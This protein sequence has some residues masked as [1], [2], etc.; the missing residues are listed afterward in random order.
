MTRPHRRNRVLE[1][2]AAGENPIRVAELTGERFQN[3]YKWRSDA[4]TLAATREDQ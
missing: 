4:R 3:V 2:L 1:L